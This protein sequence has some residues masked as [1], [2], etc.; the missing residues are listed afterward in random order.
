MLIKSI[1]LATAALA[2]STSTNAALIDRLGKPAYYDDQTDLIWL[3][4]TNHA[5][6]TAYDDASYGMNTN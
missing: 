6:T 5:N 1:A 3:A 4:D 2:L